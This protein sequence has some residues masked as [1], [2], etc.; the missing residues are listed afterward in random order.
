MDGEEFGHGYGSFVWYHSEMRSS[1]T[2]IPLQILSLFQLIQP[3][4]EILECES[5]TFDNYILLYRVKRLVFV[6][7][8]IPPLPSILDLIFSKHP[9]T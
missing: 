7:R 2:T 6:D 1:I 3:H 9:C 4:C 8:P 5:L